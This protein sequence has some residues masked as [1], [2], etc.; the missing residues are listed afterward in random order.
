MDWIHVTQ[1]SDQSR[2]ARNSIIIILILENEGNV[3]D[4]WATVSFLRWRVLHSVSEWLCYLENPDDTYGT[5]VKIHFEN[6]ENVGQDCM[7]TDFVRGKRRYLSLHKFF[8]E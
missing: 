7:L 5:K 6:R 3:V 2:T 1:D 4:S 8:Y